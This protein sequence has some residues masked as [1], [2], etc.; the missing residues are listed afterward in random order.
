LAL[1]KSLKPRVRVVIADT[2]L[3][4]AFVPVRFVVLLS[5]NRLAR[6]GGGYGDQVVGPV[7]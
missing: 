7:A 1:L 3:P 5:A 6:A 4:S 2:V